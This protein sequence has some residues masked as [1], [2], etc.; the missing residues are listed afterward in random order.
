M[1]GTEMKM[2]VCGRDGS[3][4]VISR[5]QWERSACGREKAVLGGITGHHV[6]HVFDVW[7]DVLVVSRQPSLNT[8]SSSTS[9]LPY[10][11]HI[12]SI[13]K[14]NN[15]VS[16]RPARERARHSVSS[17]CSS[18]TLAPPPFISEPPWDID[19]N[20]TSF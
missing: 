6:H 1:Y 15:E 18:T 9:S 20:R 14:A 8:E 7:Y 17:P 19:R 16:N 5:I 2:L 13:Y 3:R 11:E 12:L 10:V 4:Y